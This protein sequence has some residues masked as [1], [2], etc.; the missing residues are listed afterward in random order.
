MTTKV[1]FDRFDAEN[2]FVWDLFQQ[3]ALEAI[4]AGRKRLSVSLIIERIR[5]ETTVVRS[6]PDGFKINNNFRAYYARKFHRQYPAFSSFFTTRVS[7]AD[8]P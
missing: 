1:A 4:Y 7:A 3:F 6:D 5:W 8:S 2:P